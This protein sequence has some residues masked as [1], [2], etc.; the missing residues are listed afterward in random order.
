M[1]KHIMQELIEDTESSRPRSYSGRGMYGRECL[2][3]DVAD[4]VFALVADLITAARE[5]DDDATFDVLEEALRH[6]RTDSMGRG[7]VLYFPGIPYVDE[8]DE[9]ELPRRRGSLVD[10]EDECSC[11]DGSC[12]VC[13]VFNE[14]V[15]S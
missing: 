13:R 15:L 8:E 14:K 3:V 7:Q 2:A 5:L 1:D 4:G 12:N 10:E 11:D 6:A 9:D